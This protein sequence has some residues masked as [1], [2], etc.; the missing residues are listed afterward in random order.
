[1]VMA[2]G[3]TRRRCK[4]F[5]TNRIINVYARICVCVYIFDIVLRVYYAGFAFEL[6]KALRLAAAGNREN[7]RFASFGV[8]AL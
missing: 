7:N 5:N 6:V 2:G 3:C 1:M 4:I 8:F